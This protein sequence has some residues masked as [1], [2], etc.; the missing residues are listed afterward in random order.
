MAWILSSHCTQVQR[1]TTTGVMISTS[2]GMYLIVQGVSLSLF[3]FTHIQN[4]QSNLS[5][6][7]FSIVYFGKL[8]LIGFLFIQNQFSFTVHV[9]HRVCAQLNCWWNNISRADKPVWPHSHLKRT[10]FWMEAMSGYA[11][12]IIRKLCCSTW[13]MVSLK[14]SAVSLVLALWSTESWC[15]KISQVEKYALHVSHLKVNAAWAIA[16][17]VI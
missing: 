12:L 7:S 14:L 10:P 1:R 8:I 16:I 5:Y 9:E 2:F 6:C 3:S 13:S 15:R 17:V 4:G 11:Q